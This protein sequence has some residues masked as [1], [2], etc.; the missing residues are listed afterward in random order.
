M[1]LSI[2]TRDAPNLSITSKLTARRRAFLKSRFRRWPHISRYNRTSI[3]SKKPR[4]FVNFARV[5]LVLA[6]ILTLDDLNILVGG[7]AYTFLSLVEAVNVA[8]SCKAVLKELEMK[9]DRGRFC[10]AI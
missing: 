6:T 4:T 2:L 1:A 8:V 5:A 3:T 7:K 10:H 9:M